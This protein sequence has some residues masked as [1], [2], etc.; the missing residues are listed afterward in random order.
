MNRQIYFFITLRPYDPQIIINDGENVLVKK[1]N[2][3]GLS[4]QTLIVVP[5]AK[6]ISSV[7]LWA[8]PPLF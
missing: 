4:E 2:L 3:K 6:P 1:A 8:R 7:G 5:K